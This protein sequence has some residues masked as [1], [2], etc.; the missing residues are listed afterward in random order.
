MQHL[1]LSLAAVACLAAV[2]PAAETPANRQDLQEVLHG[3]WRGGPCMGLITFSADG[4]FERRHYSPGN[5]EIRGTWALRWD[6]LPPTLVMTCKESNDPS[7]FPAGK[8]W[9]LKVVRLD[10][11]IFEYAFSDE[12][13]STYKRTTEREIA[14]DRV[15]DLTV[16]GT[17][18]QTIGAFGS[19]GEPRIGDTFELDLGALPTNKLSFSRSGSQEPQAYIPLQGPISVDHLRVGKAVTGPARTAIFLSTPDGEGR[20]RIQITA[21][22]LKPG[23]KVRIGFSR[24][25]GFLGSRA[26]AEGVFK[27]AAP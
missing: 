6:A 4:T 24:D 11:H 3:V 2:A 17:I 8:V 20:L 26:E 15:G 5:N 27:A 22:S 12:G 7:S 9:E 1:L 10:A 18:T 16:R 19:H 14:V 25:D 21:D 13:S 23:G